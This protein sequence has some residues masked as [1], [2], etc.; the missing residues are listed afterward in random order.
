MKIYKA[1]TSFF[2]SFRFKLAF[3]SGDIIFHKFPDL[4]PTS[5][6]DF[7]DKFSF[8]N[9]FTQPTQTTPSTAISNKLSFA[10]SVSVCFLKSPYI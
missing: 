8:F 6:K 10:V 2:I 3:T 9:G 4:H 1:A 7:C 5:E